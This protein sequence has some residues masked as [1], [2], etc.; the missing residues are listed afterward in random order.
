MENFIKRFEKW[1]HKPCAVDIWYDHGFRVTFSR[2]HNIKIIRSN[3]LETFSKL[4]SEAD[5]FIKSIETCTCGDKRIYDGG[6]RE[7]KKEFY[8]KCKKCGNK[9]TIPIHKIVESDKKRVERK[10]N[11]EKNAIF[12]K[13][14]DKQN[15]KLSTEVM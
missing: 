15:R 13:K 12:M 3:E 7:G 5:E 6:K 2:W 9:I 11:A 1:I 10:K 8:Y 4:L 14:M